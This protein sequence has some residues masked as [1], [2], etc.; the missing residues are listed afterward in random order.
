MS[1][2]R[3]TVR[4]DA[5]SAAEEAYRTVRS[6]VKFASGPTPLRSILVVDLDRDNPSGV[7]EQ[8]ARAFARA[9]DTCALV[10][11]NVRSGRT[12]PGF[13]DVVAGRSALGEVAQASSISGLTEIPPGTVRDPDLL[14]GGRLSQALDALLSQYSYVVLACATLPRHADALALAPRVDAV[15]LVT[16]AGK[17]RRARA[18]EA[19]DALERVGAHMLGVVMIESRRR[20]FW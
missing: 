16:T 13:S 8:L 2:T 3:D 6:T 4:P 9:G 18:V 20:L 15:I 5:S 1:D 19:R 11:T 17:T 12:E 14:A 7:A 10:D